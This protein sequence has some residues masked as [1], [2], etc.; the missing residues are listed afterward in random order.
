MTTMAAV[1][2]AAQVS[3]H[4]DLGCDQR[5]AGYVRATRE[6]VRQVINDLYYQ[7]SRHCAVTESPG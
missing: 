1:V 5:Q 7:L 4:T 2:K 3:I 6:R